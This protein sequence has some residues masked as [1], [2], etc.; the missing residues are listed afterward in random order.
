MSQNLIKILEQQVQES[1]THETDVGSQRERNHRYYS[2]QPLGNEKPGRSHYIDPR[3][4]SA[5]EE[6]KGVFDETFLSARQ[7]VRFNGQNHQESEAKTAYAQRILKDNHYERLFRD[8]WHDAFV[9]KRC[10]VWVDW[11][12][13][14]DR[15]T[16]NL[17]GAPAQQ[18][19]AQLAQMGE[20]VGVDTAQLTRQESIDPM[21]NVY[22]V[23][24]GNLT[25]E[26]DQSYISLDLVQPEYVYRDPNR[27]YADEAL[28]NTKQLDVSRI[29]L[30]DMGYDREQ[31]ERLTIDYRWGQREEDY[32]RKR[33][34]RSASQ[35][36]RRNDM[37]E[38]VT[39]YKTRTWLTLTDEIDEFQGDGQ[40]GIYEITWGHG[41]ILRWAD[42]TVAV[43]K[44]EEMG[45]YEWCELKVSHAESG[46]CTADVEAHQQ[47]YGSGIKRGIVDNMNITNNPRWLSDLT[48]LRDDR[49]LLDNAIGGVVDTKDMGAVAPLP[50]P[51]L[52]PMVGL[53]MQ[54]LD[55]DSE[56]RSGM[57]DLARG[58][59]QGAVSNQN[60]DSMIERLTT[61]GLRRVAKAA[62]S[63]ATDFL[64]PLMQCICRYGKQYDKSRDVMESGGRQIVIQP[65]AWSDDESMEVE[66]ALTPDEVQRM[67]QR[68]ISM[69]QLL[70]GDEEM[71]PLY[72]LQQKHALYDTVFEMMG[73]KDSTKFMASLG[74]PQH[75]Q[76]MQ[77]AQQQQQMMM[78]QQEQARQTQ[79]E[80]LASRERYQWAELNNKIMDTIQD[81]QREDEKLELDVF[82]AM[83][84]I[85]LEETQERAVAV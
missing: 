84:E 74:S 44:I 14:T 78:A 53:A 24:T 64:I 9:A 56:T 29:E 85:R 63:F 38:E 23:L 75:Q 13:D 28:W 40:P 51:Q 4:F 48:K 43:K 65:S 46:L 33:H 69:N 2:M 15:V 42:G 61:A 58:M 73:V 52:S 54:M 57:S 83:E 6:K 12:R 22:V 27:T 36:G 39:V 76:F 7:V 71:K 41:E 16:I 62:R 81:N 49:D 25:V 47:K 80:I 32:A 3:V 37:Q 31:V 70:S 82:K 8:C 34:D 72:G 5:V 35:I 20:I 1:D 79:E 18:V 45:V 11:K 67:A 30:I 77:N 50:Q 17:L 60:A 10:T 68:L 19:N 66:V 55:K 26:V 21:G 59:N